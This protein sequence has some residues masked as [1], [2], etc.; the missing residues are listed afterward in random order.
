M[1]IKQAH[2]HTKMANLIQNLTKNLLKG[3]NSL[4]GESL[5]LVNPAI[6]LGFKSGTLSLNSK[7][8]P[9]LA[10][11]KLRLKSTQFVCTS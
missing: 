11:S 1:K 2:Q 10:H 4:H 6:P 8:V 9:T 3:R 5:G 7:Y